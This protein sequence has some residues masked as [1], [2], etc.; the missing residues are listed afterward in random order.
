MNNRARVYA[1]IASAVVPVTAAYWS[2]GFY[3][4]NRLVELQGTAGY[5]RLEALLLSAQQSSQSPLTPTDLGTIAVALG[6]GYVYYQVAK[7]LTRGFA[8]LYGARLE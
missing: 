3:V 6:L 4:H 7:P 5:E 2:A 8:R 1:S